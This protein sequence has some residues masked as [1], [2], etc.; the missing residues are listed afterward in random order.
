MHLQRQRY[1]LFSY[2]P[3]GSDKDQKILYSLGEKE[4]IHALWS[5]LLS[6]F[7]E[8]YAYKSGLW[9]IRYD[10]EKKWGIIRCDNVTKERVITALSFITEIRN[11]KIIFHTLKTSGTIKKILKVQ[12][13][14]FS[15]NFL[16]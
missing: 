1:I 7:G 16:N 3:I 9:M 5:S 4:I 8:Y 11:Q 14:L 10:Q 13:E 2:L 15:K 6:L 12:R